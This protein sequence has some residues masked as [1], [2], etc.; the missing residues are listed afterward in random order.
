[1]TEA[2]NPMPRW[3]VPLLV[4]AVA[5][6][7]VAAFWIGGRLALGLLWGAVTVAFGVALAVGGRSETLRMLRGTEDDER[8]LLLEHKAMTFVAL[9]LVVALA[10]LFLAAGVRGDSGLVYGLLL[11]LAEATH[12]AA[13]AVLGRRS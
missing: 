3:L 12:V 2:H 1:M 13:L 5:V 11:V 4:A 8:T 10:G 6:P 7:T 9:V